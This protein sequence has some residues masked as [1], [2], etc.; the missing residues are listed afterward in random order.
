[1]KKTWTKVAWCKVLIISYLMEKKVNNAGMWMQLR[2]RK[3]QKENK[4][5]KTQ[6]LVGYF[7][8]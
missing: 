5:K 7:P 3:T 2:A 8:E 4:A 6:A 1:M